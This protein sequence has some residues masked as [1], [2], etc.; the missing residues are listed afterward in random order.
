MVRESL[1][2]ALRSLT[3]VSQD[4]QEGSLSA[5][6]YALFLVSF[7]LIGL[8]FGV[9]SWIIVHFGF[10]PVPIFCA[11]AV[12]ALW[13]ALSGGKHIVEFYRAANA[14]FYSGTIAER[15]E[16]LGKTVVGLRGLGL[17][18]FVLS[19]K[20]MALIQAQALDTHS[21]GMLVL[22]VPMFSRYVAALVWLIVDNRSAQAQ[23][24]RNAIVFLCSMVVV[25]CSSFVFALALLLIVTSM[26]VALGCKVWFERRLGDTKQAMVS[27]ALELSEA[28]MLWTVAL[29][30]GFGLNI[31]LL[32]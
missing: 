20:I 23:V 11:W 29:F 9:L 24:R 26:A 28:L 3:F 14:L 21:V 4:G 27:V 2:R 16:L 5:T 22:L 30:G 15:N 31:V 10:Q 6:D 32:M 1:R 17:M 12:P 25:L 19:A 18:F 13:F 8:G 7:P